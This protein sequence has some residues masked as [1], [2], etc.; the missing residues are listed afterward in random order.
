MSERRLRSLSNLPNQEF[1]RQATDT[2]QYLHLGLRPAAERLLAG[3]P[4]D[5]GVLPKRLIYVPYIHGQ[6]TPQKERKIQVDVRSILDLI[7]QPGDILVDGESLSEQ[8]LRG[9]ERRRELEL[10][11]E[12]ERLGIAREY[13]PNEQV[14]GAEEAVFQFLEEH[15]DIERVGSDSFDG[16]LVHMA[17]LVDWYKSIPSR[18]E[19]K[20]SLVVDYLCI[21]ARTRN[22]LERAC[23]FVTP[24]QNMIFF[25]GA[26][27]MFSV[28]GWC[29][30]HSVPFK[31]ISPK[32]QRKEIE[33]IR[34]AGGS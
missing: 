12:L 22:A 7:A 6:E 32:I 26:S 33:E 15:P 20:G 23:S 10:G 34:R 25:Q 19:N 29:K 17:I 18:D 11:G 30:R 24:N 8:I 9:E 27:H 1:N 13:Y 31:S 2:I 16:Q 14:V 4:Y 5:L 21:E 28:E 3:I